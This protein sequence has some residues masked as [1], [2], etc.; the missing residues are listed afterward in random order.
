MAYADIDDDST[1]SS[2]LA[3][4][5]AGAVLDELEV[6]TS[7]L[8]AHRQMLLGARET[9]A[10]LDLQRA[11]EVHDGLGAILARWPAYSAAQQRRIIAT[12]EYL[13]N[14]EDAQPDLRSP[15]GFADDLRKLHQLRDFLGYV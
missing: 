10:D 3:A 15:N 9:L 7:T 2:L 14:D 13:V 1:D 4:P 11:F 12:I 5:P 8:T 6:L